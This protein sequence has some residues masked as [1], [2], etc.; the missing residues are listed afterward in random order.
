ME[1]AR[2]HVGQSIS[3]NDVV[4]RKLLRATKVKS[5]TKERAK[6]IKQAERGQHMTGRIVRILHGQS[7]GFIRADDNRQLFFHRS[8]VRVALFNALAV[9]D[10]VAFE[11]IED[12]IAGPRAV[13]VKRAVGRQR[14]R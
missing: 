6:G 9:R 12:K 1:T 4:T 10:R 2:I 14:R 8:D 7:H 11:V 5:T 13:K 3:D